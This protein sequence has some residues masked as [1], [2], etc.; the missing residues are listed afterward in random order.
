MSQKRR[1]PA[2]Y[3]AAGVDSDAA[4]RLVSR[5]AELAKLTRRPEVL[6]DVGPFGG[7]FRLSLAGGESA[8][9]GGY[10]DPV[11][12]ASTDSVGTKVKL[13]SL[14]GRYDT[15]GQDLVNH[16]VNDILCAG[17]EPLFFLD[18]I[19]SAP[20]P[21]DAK[22][23]LV[24]GVVTACR[25]AGCALLG[26]ETADLPGV[27]AEGDFDLVGFI[28]GAVE[29]DAVIDGSSIQ[30][31]DALLGLASSGLHTNGYSLVRKVFGVGLGGDPDAERALLY[32]NYPGLGVTL[33]EA[34]MTPHRCYL[35]DL[36]PLLAVGDGQGRDPRPSTRDPLIKGIAHIT[37]GGLPGNVPRMLSEGLAARIDR[38]AWKPQPLFRLIQS[39][40]PSGE[41]GGIAEDEMYRTFNMGIGIV[42]AVSPPDVEAVRSRLREA[43]VVGEVVRATGDE[44]FVWR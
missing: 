35:N 12:V 21:D 8:P 44:R 15:V 34:L 29:R 7:L 28:V 13:A 31:G 41:R 16:C 24:R 36:K 14:L 17:A 23:D 33:G 43:L 39:Y 20:L 6:A 42:L 4:E 19:G 9:G 18:Y 32:A 5:I 10:R 22:V 40:D 26:G 27:Y 30:A 25:V 2:S 38:S 1:Q 3:A 11:L 37:G